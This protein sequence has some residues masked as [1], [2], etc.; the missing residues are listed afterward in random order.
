[1]KKIKLLER[2]NLIDASS[3]SKLQER[4][5]KSRTTSTHLKTNF[6]LKV[7]DYLGLKNL[8]RKIFAAFIMVIGT[9]FIGFKSYQIYG[10]ESY[11]STLLKTRTS[12]NEMVHLCQD[13]H[14]KLNKKQWKDFENSRDAFN[15]NK[16]ELLGHTTYTFADILF[17]KYAAEKQSEVSE[18]L[19]AMGSIIISCSTLKENTDDLRMQQNML[20]TAMLHKLYSH[21][22]PFVSS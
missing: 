4:F 7:Y 19:M 17:G 22:L 21:W 12:Y 15:L 16:Q 1:M 6:F 2:S 14:K 5:K 20:K 9:S 11:N 18:R 10:Y 3:H 13:N 8:I